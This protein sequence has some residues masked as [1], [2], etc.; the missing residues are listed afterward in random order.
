MK[1]LF[2]VFVWI[3]ALTLII[4]SFIK[5]PTSESVLGIEVNIWIYRLF[6]GIIAAF[7]IFEQIKIIRMNRSKSE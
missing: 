5:N 3:L 7:S 4:Y 1:K 2:N 6:W